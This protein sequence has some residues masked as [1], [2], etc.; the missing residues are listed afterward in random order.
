MYNLVDMFVVLSL[1]L[2]PCYLWQI[3]LHLP[4]RLCVKVLARNLG[5]VYG[6]GGDYMFFKKE[7]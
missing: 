2:E 3:V 4:P 5:V 6:V 7:R 1:Y